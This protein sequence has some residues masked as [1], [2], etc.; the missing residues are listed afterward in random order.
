[1]LFADVARVANATSSP[2]R[3]G[4]A[5]VSFPTSIFIRYVVGVA[6]VEPEALVQK[7]VFAQGD[8]DGAR[9]SLSRQ[10][11]VFDAGGKIV[12]RTLKNL[13]PVPRILGR[14]S[15]LLFVK[16]MVPQEGFEPPT[17]S[18][19]NLRSLILWSSLAFR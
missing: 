14:N 7:D 5:R 19:R 10:R 6:G 4:S 16:S 8:A 15:L 12:S 3:E 17:P 11:F 1:V 2:R 13:T 9:R 18:L